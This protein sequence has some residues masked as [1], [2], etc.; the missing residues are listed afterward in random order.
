MFHILVSRETKNFVY[1]KV[2]FFQDAFEI[3]KE[4]S[5]NTKSHVWVEQIENEDVVFVFNVDG[6]TWK[7]T[8]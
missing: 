8:S 7:P 1:G 2:F 3:A 5:R 6:S 4:L